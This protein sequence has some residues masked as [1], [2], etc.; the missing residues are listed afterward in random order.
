M[1]I[2]LPLTTANLSTH[3]HATATVSG[4]S[5]VRDWLA[6]SIDSRQVDADPETWMQL[7]AKDDLAAA[8]EAAIQN[9]LPKKAGPR[10]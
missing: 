2:M 7:V 5:A 3:E 8:I 4:D 10:R 6:A 9:R 1:P